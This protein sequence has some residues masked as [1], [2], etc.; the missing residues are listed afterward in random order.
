[1]NANLYAQLRDRFEPFASE[2][3]LDPPGEHSV[4]YREADELSARFA[5]ALTN[6][7]VKPGDRVVV[8]VLKSVDAVLL[9][10]A[11]LRLGAIYVPLNTSYT[12]SEVQ[13]FIDD[14]S[15]ALFVH[16]YETAVEAS[17]YAKLEDLAI[18]ARESDPQSEIVRC[19][20]DDIAAMLYTSGTTGRAKGA[21]LS[22]GNLAWNAISLHE[23]W[24]FEPGD[25]LLHVLPI[26]HVHGLFV[27]LHT[28]MLN[29]ST[30]LFM[31]SFNVESV[32]EYLPH[33]TVMMGVPTHYIRL[34]ADDEF[35]QDA[36]RSMRLFTSGSA[37]MTEPVHAEFT[38][39]TG[40]RI[41]ERYGMTEA[42][43]ITSNPY[44]GDRV[45]GTVGFTLPGVELRVCAE[46]GTP[47][48]PGEV[49]VVEMRGRN[50][51]QGYWQLPE[52]TASAHRDDGFFVTGDVGF[53]DESGRLTLEG[54]SGDMIISGGLNVY[55][56]EIELVID[57]VPGVDES[58]VIG[59]AHADFG[60]VGLA[61]VVPNSRDSVTSSTIN[62]ALS[63][64][65]AGFKR[66]KSIEF[67]DELPRNSMGKVQKSVLRQQFSE[68]EPR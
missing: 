1:V 21:M 31:N 30:V 57:A 32:L 52:K 65:L 28:A 3:F 6:H 37:P 49:G 9:Y 15:P 10:L 48:A 46:N 56:R 16:D 2:I 8:Q 20:E 34:L 14:A 44:D 23:T 55:P 27:A 63:E 19:T 60:E 38:A 54:R 36:C 18:Q 45:P 29:A 22:H 35:N 13:F 64:H 42:G 66:P 12:S 67:V 58:A 33:A 17:A 7:G 39:R 59:V 43:M 68:P 53:L 4:S 25:V 40:H 11:C 51:F 41:L 47:C 24:G 26:F 50:L 62:G 61:V 5:A